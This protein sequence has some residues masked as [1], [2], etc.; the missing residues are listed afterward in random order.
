MDVNFLEL[1]TRPWDLIF[2]VWPQLPRGA[3]E[4]HRKHPSNT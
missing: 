2:P 4:A 1:F 3:G